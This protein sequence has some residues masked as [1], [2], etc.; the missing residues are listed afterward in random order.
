MCCIL[1]TSQFTIHMMVSFTFEKVYQRGLGV[2]EE[3]SRNSEILNLSTLLNLLHKMS[4]ALSF[5][6]AC[7]GGRE[8]CEEGPGKSE[9]GIG[10]AGYKGVL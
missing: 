5:E 7:Q 6:N 4:I 9:R 3:G 2:W 1:H 10:I 8:V